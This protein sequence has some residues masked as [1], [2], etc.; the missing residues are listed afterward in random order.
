[1]DLVT[2][3][4]LWDDFRNVMLLGDFLVYLTAKTFEGSGA[5]SNYLLYISLMPTAGQDHRR[6]PDS[7][8]LELDENVTNVLG[9]K[10]FK[11]SSSHQIFISS[12]FVPLL[13]WL[14]DRWGKGR[15]EAL[16]SELFLCA[17]AALLAAL[18]WAGRLSRE[19]SWFGLDFESSQTDTDLAF[20]SGI[21]L[22][23]ALPC[24]N[25]IPHLNNIIHRQEIIWRQR[26][27]LLDIILLKWKK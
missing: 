24:N 6:T 17:L 23:A 8:Q 15:E 9:L 2:Q 12:W 26:L 11:L 14:S 3:T 21:A 22:A 20:L 27:L 25:T 13:P 5:E 19:V 7:C 18:A 10:S 16:P 1:M 4:L